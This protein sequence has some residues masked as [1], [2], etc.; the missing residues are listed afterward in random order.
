MIPILIPLR[1]EKETHRLPYITMG[2]IIL[3]LLIWVITNRI[4]RPQ[5]AEIRALQKELVQIHFQLTAQEDRLIKE[6]QKT[7]PGYFEDHTILEF[8]KTFYESLPERDRWRYR[9]W[10]GLYE[11]WRG[12]EEKITTTHKASLL[13]QWGLKPRYWNFV[14]VFT[15]MFLHGSFLHVF[16]NM[17]FLWIFGCNIED[18][19]G[20]WR[21]ILTYVSSGVS[22]AGLHAFR[23]QGSDIPC[24][25]ASGAIFGLMGIF[26]IKYLKTKIKMA[27]FWWPVFWRPYFGIRSFYAG[28][29][30]FYW[31]AWEIFYAALVSS[32]S[33]VAHWAHLGGFIFGVGLITTLKL[34]GADREAGETV[35]VQRVSRSRGFQIEHGVSLVL[36]AKRAIQADPENPKVYLFFA[37]AFWDKGQ[38]KNAGILYNLALSRILKSSEQ[39][40]YSLYLDL[41]NRGMMDGLSEKNVYFLAKSLEKQG[42]VAE[43][44]KVYIRYANRFTQGRARAYVLY[45]THLLLRDCLNRPREA[46]QVLSILKKDYPEFEW[47]TLT[48]PPNVSLSSSG[49]RK[50]EGFFTAL[51]E[52]ERIREE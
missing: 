34:L 35:L 43:A 29:L 51:K 25:G 16:G 36:Q 47:K 31:I 13:Y 33:G 26:G 28:F 52:V 5:M 41:D 39:D 8:R 9:D 38:E 44:V 45:R 15:S 30:C 48:S 7:H 21:F 46:E 37:R 32:A 20:W 22:A 24:I 10:V 40:I 18:A 27:Y 14:H 6:F 2:L 3:N 49:S 23:F 1:T 4:I 19:W 17:L 12:I 50:N 11:Q 42:Y